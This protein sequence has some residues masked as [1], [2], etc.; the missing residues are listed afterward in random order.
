MSLYDT[1]G[2]RV[3]E[4]EEKI[5]GGDGRTFYRATHL[6]GLQFE[7]KKTYLLNRRVVRG[8]K[9]NFLPKVIVPIPQDGSP[10]HGKFRDW[11]F[12][13]QNDAHACKMFLQG[14]SVWIR[15]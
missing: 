14:S 11:I 6:S 15:R 3:L 7:V 2:E 12:Q 4:P 9:C 13:P 1:L 8:R 10:E 5:A